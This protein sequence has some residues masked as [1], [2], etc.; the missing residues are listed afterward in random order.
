MAQSPVKV[1]ELSWWWLDF[2]DGNPIWADLDFDIVWATRPVN[3]C[4]KYMYLQFILTEFLSRAVFHAYSVDSWWCWRKTRSFPRK[5]ALF[6]LCT[7]R[8]N[9]ILIWERKKYRQPHFHTPSY[10]III[11]IINQW[12]RGRIFILLLFHHQDELFNSSPQT[13]PR[14]WNWRRI[15]RSDNHYMKKWRSAHI[16]KFIYNFCLPILLL[17]SFLSSANFF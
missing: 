8:N 12:S 3:G 6:N 2:V 9:S 14:Q 13:W 11:P 15:L 17:L 5:L 4:I 1:K 16:L 7:Q 10:C